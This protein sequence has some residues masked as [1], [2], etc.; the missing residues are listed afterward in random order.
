MKK[1]VVLLAV[2]F[3]IALLAAP[4]LA[5]NNGNKSLDIAHSVYVKHFNMAGGDIKR[6]GDCHNGV[7]ADMPPV[8]QGRYANMGGPNHGC[9]DCHDG[10][11]AVLLPLPWGATSCADCH[12]TK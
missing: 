2:L 5:G 6:C 8:L 12:P 4:A 1:L 11:K 10:V 3:V 9:N 7:K